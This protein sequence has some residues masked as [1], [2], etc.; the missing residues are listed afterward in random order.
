MKILRKVEV[1]VILMSSLVLG[2]V[3]TVMDLMFKV[4]MNYLPFSGSMFLWFGSLEPPYG[5]GVST[6]I[7]LTS[8]LE[9]T[10]IGAQFLFF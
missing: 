5:L 6:K 9:L 1:L 3:A 8:L 4:K 2:K 10:W 7:S